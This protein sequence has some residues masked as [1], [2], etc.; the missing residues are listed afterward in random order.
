MATLE[1]IEIECGAVTLRFREDGLPR[2]IA[3]RGFLQFFESLTVGGEENHRITVHPRG[4][5]AG[6]EYLLRF[7]QCRRVRVFGPRIFRAE[8]DERKRTFVR[9][10]YT[11]AGESMHAG[12]VAPFAWIPHVLSDA[13]H[14]FLKHLISVAP[15]F[16]ATVRGKLCYR[17]LGC[18]PVARVV[19]IKVGGGLG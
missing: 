11:A 17:R 12:E 9:H 16:F 19:L 4:A 7:G 3:P 1:V 8:D 5:A 2:Q 14:Y 18:I 10:I 6:V 13:R 15:K